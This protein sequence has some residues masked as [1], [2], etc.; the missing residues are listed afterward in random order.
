MKIVH[1]SDTHTKHAEITVPPCDMLI[2][3]GD[4]GS[5]TNTQE[6][7][8]FLVWLEGQPATYKIWTA[9]NHD[10]CLDRRFMQEN[11]PV[12]A[13]F[14]YRQYQEAMALIGH[15]GIR[16]LHNEACCIGDLCIYGAAW[17]PSF[18][19]AS[20]AFNQDRGI[21]IAKQWAKIP[22]GVEILITHT[23][24]VNV[25]DLVPDRQKTIPEESENVGCEDLWKVIR[26]RL[27]HLK[28]HCFGHIHGNY[29][30]LKRNVTNKRQVLF[31]NG[32]VLDNDYK[33]SVDKPL[34]IE[35]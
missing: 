1:I 5:R 11:H 28:L 16:Y 27:L 9:G 22:S 14:G 29:G 7:I 10:L 17:S 6:L 30:V 33:V 21:E 15:Y 13:A 19:R 24:P 20:W 23:P 3:S 25:L 35:L 2:H 8:D 31:S 4:I 26:K 18:H 12:S 32:A 34:I